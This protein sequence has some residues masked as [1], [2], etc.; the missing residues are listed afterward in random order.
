MSLRVGERDGPC[1]NRS[2]QSKERIH[3][4]VPNT[5]GM[6]VEKATVASTAYVRSP[7][8]SA[9]TYV[10]FCVRS[11]MASKN[12]PGRH[13]GAKETDEVDPTPGQDRRA[14][15]LGDQ[16]IRR[17]RVSQ[18]EWEEKKVCPEPFDP[19]APVQ[20]P[21]DCDE[22]EADPTVLGKRACAL[23]PCVKQRRDSC[24]A[25][26][27]LDAATSQKCHSRFRPT[28]STMVQDGPSAVF[29][30]RKAGPSVLYT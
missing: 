18:P 19:E 9:P 11:L 21:R 29:P 25:G 22:T 6:T 10:Q 26:G 1:S 15:A 4:E 2:I 23:H 16:G 30:H 13:G 5:A 27:S 20:R 7:K 12:P 28:L 8:C 17:E 3:S 14:T 24:R